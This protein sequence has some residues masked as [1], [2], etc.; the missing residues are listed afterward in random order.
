MSWIGMGRL[1]RFDGVVVRL[2]RSV[3]NVFR[4]VFKDTWRYAR[5]ATT[6]CAFAYDY[7]R[8]RRLV[9]LE[10]GFYRGSVTEHSDRV[11]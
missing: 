6:P 8:I 2:S 7:A 11:W 1:R 4:V 10:R 3:F 9:R 5:K